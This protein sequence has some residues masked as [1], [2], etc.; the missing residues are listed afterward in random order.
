MLELLTKIHGVEF[1]YQRVIFEFDMNLCLFSSP[2]Y[3]AITRSQVIYILKFRYMGHD[4]AELF[5]GS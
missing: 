4:F 3:F 1:F 2:H 5:I